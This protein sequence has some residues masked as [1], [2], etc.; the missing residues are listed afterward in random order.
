MKIFVYK[1]IIFC[2]IVL[3]FQ[4]CNDSTCI[5]SKGKEITQNIFVDTFSTIMIYG[6][7]DITLLPDT[8][9]YITI[10]GGKNHIELCSLQ[11]SQGTIKW[12]NSATCGFFKQFEHIALTIHTTNL[13][14]IILYSPCSLITDTLKRNLFLSAQTEMI[15][16]QIIV[17]NKLT[18]IDTYYKAG[19][20][21]KIKGNTDVCNITANYT[22]QVD[23]KYLQTTKAIITNNTIQDMYIS[24]SDS[25]VAK[26]SKS[27][28]IYFSGNPQF[29]STKGNIKPIL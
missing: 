28:Y 21:L 14:S 23:S 29:I 19:G 7:C 4:A 1:I 13:D 8:I 25:L 20:L 11:Q 27:G 12:Y 10:H 6:I 16:A 9:N 26:T 3:L 5:Q 2:C 22:I 15:K 17:N 24:V 18:K